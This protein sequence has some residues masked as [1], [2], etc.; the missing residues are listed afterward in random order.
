MKY[1]ASNIQYDTD[2]FDVELPNSI[3]IDV[4]KSEHSGFDDI[5]SISDYVSDEISSITGYC[6]KGFDLKEW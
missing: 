1:I 3:I 2:G 5:D 6:H 4:P